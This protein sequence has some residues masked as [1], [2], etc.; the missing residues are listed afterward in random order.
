MSLGSCAIS[1]WRVGRHIEA[2]PGTCHEITD[3]P[4]TGSVRTGL[5]RD[6]PVVWRWLR[7]CG[8]A[9]ADLRAGFM[10]LSEHRYGGMAPPSDQHGE[11]LCPPGRYGSPSSGGPW[12]S[13]G[14][15]DQERGDVDP[16]KTCHYWL[17]HTSVAQHRAIADL[18]QGDGKRVAADTSA[19]LNGRHERWR[20]RSACATRSQRRFLLRPTCRLGA[21]TTA[22]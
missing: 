22:G 10:W 17:G 18:F 16:K 20:D 3:R 9:F 11:C 5:E 21:R 2:H 4:G 15:R 1:R 14:E 19:L 8:G 12:L 6:L 7:T 13:P